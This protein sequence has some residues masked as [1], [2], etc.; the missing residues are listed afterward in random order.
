MKL[1]RRFWLHFPASLK[2]ILFPEPRRRPRSKFRRTRLGT[3]RALAFQPLE[4]K[5]LLTSI[6]IQ[7]MSNANAQMQQQGGFNLMAFPAPTQAITVSYTVSGSAVPND[8]YHAL[9]GTL[10]IAANQSSGTIS[11]SPILTNQDGTDPT[12]IVT[13]TSGTGYTLSSPSSATVNIQEP[14]SPPTIS[15]V[16]PASGAT[17]GGTSVVISGSNFSSVSNVTFGGT[18]GTGVTVNSSS[19][20]TVVS[21]SHAAGSVDIV[22]NTSMNG[23][24]ATGA[25]DRFTYNPPAPTVSGVSPN[26]ASTA[27]G[28][29][30][31]ITGTNFSGVT[32]VSFGG[33]A[34]SSYTVTSSTSI[35]AVDPAESVGT[36]NVTVTTSGGTSATGSQDQFTYNPPAPSVSGV[37]AA[38][39]P[40]GGGTTVTITG[41]GF[42]AASGVSFGGVAATSYT[43][44]S[45][46]SISA[47]DPSHAAGVVDVTVSN[48][49]GTSATSS[50]DQF[51]YQ[52][53]PAVS[54]VSPNVSPVSGGV[55]VTIS[56][57]NF[58]N[59]SGV[60]FGAVAASSYTVGSST[61]I[62]AVDPS[63]SAGTI[64]VTVTNT[65]GTSATGSADRLT[66]QLSP[67]VSA[68][69]PASGPTG[70]GTTI[71]ITGNYFTN[72][73]SVSLG[74]VAATSYTVNSAT[75]IT[76][77]TPAHAASV[78]DVVVT[79]AVG[80]SVTSSADQFAYDAPAPT[81][82][83]V[84]PASGPAAEGTVVTISGTNFSGATSVMFGTTAATTFTVN[85][86]TQITATAPAESAA[87]VDVTIVGPGGTSAT[88]SADQFTFLPA[89][90]V[91]NGVTPS[92]G[93][94]AG[95]ATVT[96]SGAN[97]TSVQG[98][99]FGGAAVNTYTVNSSTQI[100]A[101]SP[102]HAAGAVDV[103]VTN[104]GGSSSTSSTDKFT[105]NAP[106]PTVTSVSPNSGTSTGGASVTIT[107]TNFSSVS[108]VSFGGVAAANYTVNSASSITATS[109][110]HSAG[111]VDITVTTSSATSATGSGDQFTYT[112]AAPSVSGVSPNSGTTMGAVAVTI[113]GA[114]FNN[115]T[116]V[117]FGGA[118]AANYTVNSATSISAT[119]PPGSAGTVNVTVSNSGGTSATVTADQ[120]TYIEPAPAVTSVGPTSGPAAGE[121]WSPSQ[122]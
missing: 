26:S 82:T 97:F 59:V 105:Y 122:A 39:G 28:T 56:G 88:G 67:T 36:V 69:S 66:Y 38:S 55:S 61:S 84:S 91:V 44:N 103:V 14:S 65:G 34:A 52:A 92:S 116:G 106:A 23:G 70:G 76:A 86:A 98:I 83:G 54:G 96:I 111:V 31:T 94:T 3:G 5:Q 62:T 40:L 4:P 101:T 117:S 120:F 64:D 104:T 121:P 10:T 113:S 60:K 51:T 75:Q 22:V 95:G 19:Q 29:T 115:V 48:A 109:P 78:V 58:A 11:V 72:V 80:S 9:S 16:S 47:V 79:S 100:T 90:P 119:A 89:A 6:T 13:L 8:S 71:V 37:S 68:V 30:V 1:S 41:S 35:S 27:G 110:V 46:T 24:S 32:G 33:T 57:S 108:G 87:L 102:T 25:N 93:A 49:G 7:E 114:N 43:V 20:V 74:G 21:P 99:T 107:G 73:T 112:Q 18:P 81:V 45:S 15:S 2:E 17:A 118:A 85:S 12:V 53:A 77:T 50:A 42:T 63:E